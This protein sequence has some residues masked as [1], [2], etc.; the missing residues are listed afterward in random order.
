VVS[1]DV[2]RRLR[3]ESLARVERERRRSAVRGL[4]LG[5]SLGTAIM[6]Y[7][8]VETLRFQL[9]AEPPVVVVEDPQLSAQRELEHR[10][11]EIQRDMEAKLAN[12]RSDA[13]RAM[14]RE[15]YTGR[16]TRRHHGP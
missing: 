16:Q 5:L 6:G 11:A 2:I 15:G 1:E 10:L 13:E 8:A 4:A 3:E 9:E 7:G 12:A 14:I